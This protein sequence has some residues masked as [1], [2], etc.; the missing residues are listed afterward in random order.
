MSPKLGSKM[1]LKSY[2]G[3]GARPRRGLLIKRV[4][5]SSKNEPNRRAIELKVLPELVHEVALIAKVDRVGVI[6]VKHEGR[7]G[8]ARLRHII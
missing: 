2:R 7:G 5:F 6:T 1:T 3:V 8:R 4:I